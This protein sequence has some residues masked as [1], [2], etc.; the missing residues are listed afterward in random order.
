RED[1]DPFLG[2]TETAFFERMVARWELTDTPAA[3]A[4]ER[5]RLSL[6]ALA[7]GP[8]LPVEGALESLIWLRA[9]GYRLG[10]A[11]A[12]TAQHGRPGTGGQVRL[13]IERFGLR[14]VFGAVVSADDVAHGKPAPD[15]FL[16]AA[17]RLGVQPSECL[18]VEDAALGV[19]AARAAG[20]AAVAHVPAGVDGSLHRKA[21]AI[22]W[23][24]S[25]RGLAPGLVGA[26]SPSPGGPR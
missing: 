15:L 10:R 20:M 3:L 11:S 14:R 13:V 24:G 1:Y 25:M 17:R 16:E 9:D 2:L 23:L 7:N 21:G 26:V 18:V 22:A 5:L 6:D 19:Q 12:A 8:L 4:A